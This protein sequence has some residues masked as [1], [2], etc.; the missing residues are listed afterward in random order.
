M[1]TK[2]VLVDT[3]PLVAILS[4]T[5][6]HHKACVAASQALRGPFYTAWPVITEAVY[7][8]KGRPEAVEKLLGRVRSSKLCLLELVPEDVDGIQRILKDYGD[9]GFD[10]ADA[11][12]MHLAEKSGIETVFTTDRR[13]FSVYRTDQGKPLT[14]VP[15]T[16]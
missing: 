1:A 5:D 4:K 12:L 11:T 7:L 13:H 8:L 3:G 14:L 2:G 10:L 16:L 15:A 9:Q 6:Q